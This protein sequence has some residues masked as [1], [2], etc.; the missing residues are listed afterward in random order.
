[1][2]SRK[3]ALCLLMFVCFVAATAPAAFAQAAP[4]STQCGFQTLSFSL[5]PN[6]GTGV[7]AL[8]DVGGIL[9]GFV[10]SASHGSGFLQYQGQ[11]TTFMFP[12]STD[13]FPSDMNTAGTI[14]GSYIVAGNANTHAFMVQSGKFHEITIPGFSNMAVTARGVNDSNDVVGQVGS[15]NPPLGPGY[16]LHNGAV[17]VLSFPGA[18]GGTQ[19][20]SI[21]N[22]GVV[23]GNYFLNAEDH[24]HGFMWKNG[25]FSNV[26]PPQSTGFTQ[27]KKISNVGDAVGTY[28]S[29]ADNHSHGFVL[30]DGTYT[31]IDV[32]GSQDSFIVAVNKFDNILA[33]AQQG[34][35]DI[36]DKGFC[37]AV[38]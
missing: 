12:G 11:L 38:F 6:N 5:P 21:N 18:Q 22:Q 25:V 9:G 13:T 3:I 28:I 15:T 36:H 1:M 33:D 10:T 16:L 17:T 7:A 26:N 20:N 35:N 19:P 14:V 2:R 4:T 31:T 32:P 29:A 27:V 8:N 24:P 23:V 37:S 30:H 34:A